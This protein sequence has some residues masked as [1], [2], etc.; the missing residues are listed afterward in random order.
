M[1]TKTIFIIAAVV[2]GTLGLMSMTGTF[3]PRVDSQQAYGY[4]PETNALQE[5]YDYATSALSEA[6]NT[7]V[8]AEQAYNEALKSE[9]A[10]KQSQCALQITL[11]NSKLKD[12]GGKDPSEATRLSASVAEGAKCLLVT[13]PAFN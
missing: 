12:V 2:T 9:A 8:L 4:S 7:R 13:S 10:A 6:S 11:G 1:K 5:N 3:L